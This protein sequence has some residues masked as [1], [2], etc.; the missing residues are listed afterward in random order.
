MQG[1]FLKIPGS[2]KQTQ[3]L[4]L[5]L[6]FETESSNKIFLGLF[7]KTYIFWAKAMSLLTHSNQ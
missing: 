5:E 2:S 4:N 7:K 3:K 6:S 1:F